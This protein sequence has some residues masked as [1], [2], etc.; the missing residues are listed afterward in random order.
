MQIKVVIGTV[1]FMLTMIILGFAALMEPARMERYT[2]AYDGRRIEQG[3]EV[4]KNNCSTCHGVNGDAQVCYDAAS[5][6][7]IPC[8]GFPLNSAELVCGIRSP[9]ME[10][11]AW[12]GTKTDYVQSAIAAGRPWAGMPTWSQEF[13]G[14]LQQN[15]VENVTLFVL[16]WENVELCAEPVEAREWPPVE[17]LDAFLAEFTGDP[18]RGEEIYN[19]VA[20][21]C[22]A[23]HGQ[24]DDPAT[25]RAGPHLGAIA[26]VGG[27]R[28]PGYT[29]AQYI[30]ESIL[31][32]DAAIAP[33]CPNP[34]DPAQPIACA[35]PSQM[36]N[37]FG[38]ALEYQDMADLV[39]FLLQQR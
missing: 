37:V 7:Q 26:T 21:S 16:N 33:A 32:P 24:M 4:Y 2:L 1:A 12:L 39:A 18:A 34:A 25:A 29:A 15:Q 22:A 6:E 31:H 5:G 10:A 13:G 20:P 14:P 9:R 27:D 3:A 11:R 28:V 19:T 38:P 35:S 36:P 8:I 17:E 30:Y 23:C